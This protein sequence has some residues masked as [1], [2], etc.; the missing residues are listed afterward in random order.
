MSQLPGRHGL[1]DLYGCNE[2]LLRDAAAL[3]SV[4]HQAAL[5]SGA[6]VLGGHFHTFGGGGGVSG[7]LLLAESHISIHTWPERQFAA[8]DIFLCGSHCPETAK[9][10]LQQA[11]SAH[12]A[13]WQVYPRGSAVAETEKAV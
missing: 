10:S 2:H 4:L 5:H 13:D 7:V 11:L 6:T 9:D 3:Q 12:R 1:L 8:V